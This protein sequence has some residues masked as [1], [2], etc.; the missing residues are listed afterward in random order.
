MNEVALITGGTRGIGLGIARELAKLGC[1]LA[2]NGVRE[3]NSVAVV[4][5]LEELSATGIDVI[6]CRG[7]IARFDDRQSIMDKV[8]HHY[9]QV[10]F[11]INNAGV[12]PKQRMDILDTTEESFEYVMDVNLKGPFF[13]TQAVSRLMINKKA[14]GPA[15]IGQIINVSSVSATMASPN[16]GEYSMSKSG[17]AMMTKLFASRLGEYDIP[18]YEVRPGVIETDMTAGVKEKYDRLIEDGL[19]VQPRWGKPEDVGKT[20]AAIVEGRFPYST[21]QVFMVDGGLTIPRL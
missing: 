20:V 6:Y 4:D 5:V 1:H 13:L 12:A 17:L 14:E 7:N 19:F 21:G 8:T 10:N 2:L 9:G 15:F 3:E 16:R 11:L 18:V